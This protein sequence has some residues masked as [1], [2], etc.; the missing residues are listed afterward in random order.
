M[1]SASHVTKVIGG[2]EVLRDVSLQ[3]GRGE[4]VRL[5]GDREGGR[6][7]L[8]RILAAMVRPTSGVI[9]VDGVEVS[10]DPIAAR[11]RVAYV[12][13]ELPCASRFTV[14]EYVGMVARARGV[15]VPPNAAGLLTRAGVSHVADVDRL[16]AAE[17]TAVA[18]AAALVGRPDVLLLENVPADASASV[19]QALAA[20]ISDARTSGLAIVVAVDEIEELLCLC[21]RVI[22]LDGGHV[23]R[24]LAGL[25]P[26]DLLC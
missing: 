24:G 3:V 8:L 18:V 4:C 12:D 10:H 5:R 19:R 15:V 1:I 11:R 14:G 16:A 9:A 17:R 23:H 25:T 2:R 13:G 22:T 20:S 6:T 21:G 26:S 7:T